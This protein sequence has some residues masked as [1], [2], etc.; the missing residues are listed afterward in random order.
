MT[1]QPIERL[2][3]RPTIYALED[4]YIF[5]VTKADGS[6]SRHIKGANLFS[7]VADDWFVLV[8]QDAVSKKVK[9]SNLAGISSPENLWMLVNDGAKSYKVKASDVIDKFTRKIQ[10]AME[11]EADG[12]WMQGSKDNMSGIMYTIS[13]MNKYD[14]LNDV[15]F[16]DDPRNYMALKERGDDNPDRGA[17]NGYVDEASRTGRYL[18]CPGTTTDTFSN[19]DLVTTPN[20]PCGWELWFWVNNPVGM[21]STGRTM[22]YCPLA[23][24]TNNPPGSTVGPGSFD[25][26]VYISQT[27]KLYWG[28]YNTETH[29]AKMSYDLQLETWHHIV[30]TNDGSHNIIYHNGTEVARVSSNG[31]SAD[32]VNAPYAAIGKSTW[33]NWPHAY[34]VADWNYAASVRWAKVAYYHGEIPD[35][36]QIQASGYTL[37]P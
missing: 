21:D 1:N 6:E 26:L 13:W 27:R 10:P 31:F 35:A 15:F 14:K 16:E 29:V 5:L 33:R 8:N 37:T 32:I 23:G 4:D 11:L 12:W 28:T 9:V 3:S 22:S 20:V 2:G 30:C 17:T 24:M 18:L 34:P 36:G 7:G 19:H 25:R